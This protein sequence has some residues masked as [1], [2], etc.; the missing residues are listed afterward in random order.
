M[1]GTV[2]KDMKLKPSILDD[3]VKVTKQQTG[4]LG[5]GLSNQHTCVAQMLSGLQTCA[6]D[7][8]LAS[9]PHGL[10]GCHPLVCC[11]V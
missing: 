8:V 11:A 4:Q 10:T 9:S 7:S 1:V 5:Q 3:Y 2:Y 6:T